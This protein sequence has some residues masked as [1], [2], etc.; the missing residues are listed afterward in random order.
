VSALSRDES[1]RARAHRKNFRK[2]NSIRFFG[3]ARVTLS[4]TQHARRARK[5]PAISGRQGLSRAK[6]PIFIEENVRRASIANQRARAAAKTCVAQA[7]RR[8]SGDRIAIVTCDDRGALKHDVNGLHKF[9]KSV[10]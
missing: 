9:L 2:K 1:D 7:A 6:K 5:T 4:D 10:G 3:A 8:R